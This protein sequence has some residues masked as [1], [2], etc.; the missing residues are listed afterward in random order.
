M[1]YS[2]S[3][4][5]L[6]DDDGIIFVRKTGDIKRNLER[7][8]V[9]SQL[10][11]RIP[12]IHEILDTHYDMEYISNL[13]MKSYLSVNR[14]NELIKFI[15]STID[16]LSENTIEMY[17]VDIYRKKLSEITFENYNLPFSAE[18][19]I[20]KL[21]KYLPFSVYH[22]DFTLENILYN[23]KKDEFVLID[24]LTTEYSSYVFDL[25]KLRQDL[26]CK[27]F[28]RNE[29]V[30]LDS[31]LRTIIESLRHYEYFNNDYILILML[32]RVLPYARNATDLTFLMD[33]INRLWK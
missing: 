8:D 12:I 17:F 22:G 13:E 19:L 14:P 9:L 5:E 7:Y 32:L 1:G 31:K 30:Y 4:V 6:L 27:W 20:S 2:K 29:S 33:E 11:I 24:P 16:K 21:P 28:I 10:D 25:A 3:D 15:K 26:E 18:E 23:T